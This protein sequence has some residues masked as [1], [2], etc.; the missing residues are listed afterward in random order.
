MGIGRRS[1]GSGRCSC[2]LLARAAAGRT[3][4]ADASHPTKHVPRMAGRAAVRP[5]SS[6]RGDIEAR[7]E[8]LTVHEPSVMAL[9]GCADS[10]RTE[11]LRQPL[12]I[13]HTHCSR[14]ILHIALGLSVPASRCSHLPTVLAVVGSEKDENIRELRETVEIL[15]VKIQKLEQVSHARRAAGGTPT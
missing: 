8:S 10:S 7:L 14:H 2:S 13:G 4:R 9:L 15:E 12:S 11:G 5:P 1:V 3:R 6:A